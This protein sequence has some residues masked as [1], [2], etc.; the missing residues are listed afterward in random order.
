LEQEGKEAAEGGLQLLVYEALRQSKRRRKRGA[1]QP[2]PR[3][4]LRNR[5]N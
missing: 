3:K 5:Q 2:A 4:T 1:C